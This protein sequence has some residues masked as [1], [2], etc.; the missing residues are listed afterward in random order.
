MAR[1]QVG[2]RCSSYPSGTLGVAN[3]PV[4]GLPNP[5]L[6][7]P[8]RDRRRMTVVLASDVCRNLTV[9]K[10]LISTHEICYLRQQRKAEGEGREFR[11]QTQCR[12]YTPS[13]TK[14][15]ST[16]ILVKYSGPNNCVDH[17]Y[18]RLFPSCY[19][20]LCHLRTS[21]IR[22]GRGA[23]RRNKKAER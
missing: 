5:T 22:I 21:C 14:H 12:I 4:F 13:R 23:D 10:L 16:S 18:T 19:N 6:H 17:S 1:W 15:T 2:I 8:R 20:R 3:Y 11:W 7:G 9:R